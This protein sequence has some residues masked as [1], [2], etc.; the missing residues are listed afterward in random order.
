MD[1]LLTTR[2]VQELLKLDRSTLYRMLK[3]GRLRG[4]RVGQQWRFTHQDVVVLLR[5]GAA[6]E[7]A[8]TAPTEQPAIAPSVDG[9]LLHCM[10][11]IQDVFADLAH[12]G[13]VTTRLDGEPLTV[14]SNACQLCALLQSSATGRHR[15]I[16]SWRALASQS[17][18][19]PHV[20]SCHAGLG[21]MHARITIDDQPTALL[22]AGQF[23]LNTDPIDAE[24]LARECGLDA[25]A[26]AV[27]AG[28]VPVFDAGARA[29]IAAALKKVAHT[30]EA[31]GRERAHMIGRL[32][33]IAALS[34]LD[35]PMSTAGPG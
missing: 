8:T 13:C 18:R 23:R 28:K 16:A 34:A 30:F 19:F 2:D 4:V 32:R 29:R 35:D 5:R 6:S 7:L 11:A 25:D 9:L 1:D 10:Q 27:A 12:V 15:C 21:Y 26:V 33:E 24:R 20:A 31:I 14:I 3:D 22:V 17:E